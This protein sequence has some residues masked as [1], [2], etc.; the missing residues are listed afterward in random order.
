M[1]GLESNYQVWLQKAQNDLLN[2]QNNL[3]AEAIP[4]DT[5]CFH[6][7]QAVE[8]TLKAFLVFHGRAIV[9][10]H[11]L[12]PLLVSCAGIEPALTV[13]EEDCQRLT[14]YAV[15]GRYPDDL[16]EPDEEDGRRM[17]EAAARVRA[18]VLAR[19]P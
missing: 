6:A 9:K 10:I 16:Y 5:V 14:Y 12:V 8:K 17:I 7:Q 11:D 1:S 18:A 15:G 4:W 19:F 13:L 2:I 3:K